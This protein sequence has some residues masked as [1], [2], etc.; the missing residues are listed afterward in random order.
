MLEIAGQPISHLPASPKKRNSCPHRNTPRPIRQSNNYTIGASPELPAADRVHNSIHAK[1]ACRNTTH[2]NSP[3][4]SI[5]RAPRTA[6]SCRP[7]IPAIPQ[8]GTE[9]MEFAA[10]SNLGEQAIASSLESI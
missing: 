3:R 8:N 6:A 4:L 2:Q 10:Q 7:W 9:A 1:S 5:F